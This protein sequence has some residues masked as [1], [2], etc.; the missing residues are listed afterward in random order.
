M[1]MKI[2]ARAAESDESYD[3][4]ANCAE[5]LALEVEKCLKIRVDPEVGNSITTEGLN[6]DSSRISKHNEGLEKPKGIKVKEK[7]TKGSRR[8]VGGFEKATRKKKKKKKDIDNI[9]QVQLQG[10]STGHLDKATRKKK[11][12]I[13]LHKCS[14]RT[15][16]WVIWSVSQIKWL[17]IHY[18]TTIS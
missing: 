16:Q 10:T 2:A 5:Q 11:K 3:K 7:T 13:I 15:P 18:S 4:A 12:Q 14:H 6:I 1:F 17:H 9:V 8:P